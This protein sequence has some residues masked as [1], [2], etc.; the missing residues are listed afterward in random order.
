LK[1][2]ADMSPIELGNLLVAIMEGDATSEHPGAPLVC[3]LAVA[4]TAVQY[5]KCLTAFERVSGRS[6]SESMGQHI[7]ALGRKA[8]TLRNR[9][10]SVHEAVRE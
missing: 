9:Y 7:E 4:L 1:P 5:F 3:E 6:V 10:L 2:A 8:D